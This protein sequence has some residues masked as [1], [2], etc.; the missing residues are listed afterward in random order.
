MRTDPLGLALLSIARNA[1][2][3]QFGRAPRTVISHPALANPAATFVTLTQK[4]E[5][6][7]CIGSLEA[8]RSL[9]QDVAE[10]AFSAAFRDPR[11]L[12]L[13]E[14]ELERTLDMI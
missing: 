1:I 7:G 9:A 2:E 6:R 13:T 12:P 11:F 8:Y 4:G 14:E 3:K 5:L 10:N